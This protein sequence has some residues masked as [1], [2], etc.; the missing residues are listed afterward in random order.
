MGSILSLEPGSIKPVKKWFLGAKV[1]LSRLGLV[2]GSELELEL[3]GDVGE[4]CWKENE[5]GWVGAGNGA[6]RV[7]DVSH[8]L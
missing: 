4:R 5:G 7:S 1:G 2:S 3:V 8:H 6:F